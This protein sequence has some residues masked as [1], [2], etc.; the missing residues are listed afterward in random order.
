M[1]YLLGV[2]YLKHSSLIDS[3]VW[4]LQTV[5]ASDFTVEM[6]ITDEMW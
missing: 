3:K 6:D 2:Y 1:I 4:D 5:T